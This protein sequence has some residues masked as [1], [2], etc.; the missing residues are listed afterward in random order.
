MDRNVKTQ[1]FYV[2]KSVRA[3]ENIISIET[4][5]ELPPSIFWVQV[6]SDTSGVISAVLAG[7]VCDLNEGDSLVVGSLYQFPVFMTEG[8][9]FNLRFSVDATLKNLIVVEKPAEWV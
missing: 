7:E 1:V 4:V 8:V 2:G 6:C 9:T 3:N 5:P